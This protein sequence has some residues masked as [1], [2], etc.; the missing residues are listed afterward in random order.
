MCNADLAPIQRVRQ[1]H[2]AEYHEAVRLAQLGATEA[3]LRHAAAAVA[4]NAEFVPGLVLLGRLLSA[5]GLL[6]EAI[7]QWEEASRLAP[8]NPEPADLITSARRALHARKRRDLAVWGGSAVVLVV[9]VLFSTLGYLSWVMNPRIGVLSEKL[10]RLETALAKPSPGASVASGA[11]VASGA[12]WQE[13]RR[14]VQ[15]LRAGLETEGNWRL[16][17]DSQIVSN[18]MTRR[19]LEALE[20][21]MGSLAERQA[22]LA[23]RL[24]D[25]AGEEQERMRQDARF[26]GEMA[27]WQSRLT[28]FTA[29]AHQLLQ[30]AGRAELAKLKADQER[31]V[32]SQE[33]EAARAREDGSLLG[34]IRYSRAQKRLATARERLAL[35]HLLWS[36]QVEPWDRLGELLR[37]N[38]PASP[39]F[40]EKNDAQK[41]PGEV[42][43]VV[44]N[45]PVR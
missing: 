19:R 35:Y 34:S 11:E 33:L 42:D 39:G 7:G 20:T 27:D 10:N 16:A 8:E 38:S 36:N 41:Q 3:S 43:R 37:T 15:A 45:R 2:L 18:A 31:E 17:L 9:C 44:N 6:A 23:T 26:H 21:N 40:L 32:A 13:L 30:P 12:Q 22:T 29:A 1:L 14:E 24:S 28:Q 4:L 25:G 5:K